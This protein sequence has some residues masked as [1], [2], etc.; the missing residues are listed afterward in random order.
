VRELGET[1]RP[2]WRGVVDQDVHRAGARGDLSASL[3]HSAS[4]DRSGYRGDR[5]Q[6]GQLAHGCCGVGLRDVMITVRRG[7]QPRAAIRPIRG[8]RR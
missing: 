1:A 4:V 7:E 2:R 5:A 3:R 6:V 8:C